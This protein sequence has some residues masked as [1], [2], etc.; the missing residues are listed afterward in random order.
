RLGRKAIGGVMPQLTVLLDLPVPA[1]FARLRRRHDR[2]ERKG[3]AFHRRV[4]AGYLA[5]ARRE[6]KRF[7]VVDARQRPAA[8]HGA[9]LQAVARRVG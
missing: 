4:R 1:G 2:M 3:L 5:L 7:L 8:I 9:I 6:P